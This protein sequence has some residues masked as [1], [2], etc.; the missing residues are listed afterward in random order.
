MGISGEPDAEPMKL[1]VA[2]VDLATGMLACIAILGALAARDR[3]GRGQQVDLSLYETGLMLLANV[4]SNHL[5]SGRDAGRF[6]NGH[7]NI[8][9]YRTY[10]TRAGALALA[11]GNDAQFARF[12]AAVARPEWGTDPRLATNSARV[13][14][15]E[16]VDR[17]VQEALAGDTAE[18]WISRLRATG[19]PCGRV[20]TV[21]QALADPQALA[22]A[23]VET[24]HHPAVGPVRTLGVPFKMAG[25]PARVRRPPPTL[26]E[27][28][29]EILGE[30]GLAPEEIA[31]LR[32]EGAI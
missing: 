13:L 11:V 16:V 8:V 29:G 32:A 10:A 5:A 19:V 26:G 4:A 30:L 18:A 23:M 7:P 2:I 17:L 6:G 14:N 3:T 25:T 20:S 12:A 9:P 24:I 28:T 22:R 31:R 15:R 1:G 21:A 27:H